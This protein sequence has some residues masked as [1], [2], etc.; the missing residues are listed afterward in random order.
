MALILTFLGKGGTGKTTVAIA[1]AKKLAS[2]GRRVL[3]LTQDPSP[4][5]P[6]ILG[7]AIDSLARAEPQEIEPRLHVLQ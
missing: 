1:V 5:F 4:A 6:L 2:Q 3:L 7:V